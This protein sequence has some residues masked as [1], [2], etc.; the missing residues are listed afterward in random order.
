MRRNR[1]GKQ[2]LPNLSRSCF[3][4]TSGNSN[5]AP[6]QRRAFPHSARRRSR[7]W[8]FWLIHRGRPLDRKPLQNFACLAQRETMARQQSNEVD[9]LI[10]RTCRQQENP[11]R[12]GRI[13]TGG[14]LCR[15][16]DGCGDVVSMLFFG[17]LLILPQELRSP[18]LSWWGTGQVFF[19][20]LLAAMRFGITGPLYCNATRNRR[21][22]HDRLYGSVLPGRGA[23][24]KRRI[25][26]GYGAG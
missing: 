9:G 6:T 23:V 1:V 15:M 10:D 22:G 2:L 7:G 26:S 5:T 20:I 8:M 12:G 17:W 3:T 19:R 16:C 21:R 25:D 24:S 4:S 14:G 18:K 13:G 11:N